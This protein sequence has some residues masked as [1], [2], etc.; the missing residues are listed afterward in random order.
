MK[1]CKAKANGPA[2]RPST[3]QITAFT[4]RVLNRETVRYE[5]S[6]GNRPTLT[7]SF[8]GARNLFEALSRWYLNT[9]L[10]FED[11]LVTFNQIA[12]AI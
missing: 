12:A 6:K 5:A 4:L 11:V 1:V 7:V 9:K 10:P 8:P 2:A 3:C